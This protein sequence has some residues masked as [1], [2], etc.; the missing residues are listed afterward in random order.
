MERF[1]PDGRVLNGARIGRFASAR[2]CGRL[3]LFKSFSGP[4]PLLGVLLVVLVLAA[5]AAVA[6][7]QLGKHPW[8]KADTGLQ[9][10]YTVLHILD[11]GQ[12]LAIEDDPDYYERNS[13]LGRDP[14]RGRINTYFATTLG[15]HW[16]IARALPPKWRNTFQAG[17]IAIQFGVVK[18][19]YE[20]GLSVRF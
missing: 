4:W 15:L 11:W 14:S 17:T 6:G 18:D 5:P 8:T 13:I 10:S 9:L 7:P 12:T 16:L 3:A 1:A 2:R 20:A 19:N